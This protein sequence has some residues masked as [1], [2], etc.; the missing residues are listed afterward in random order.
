[1]NS[2]ARAHEPTMEEILASIRR[3][4]ADD[5]ESPVTGEQ[6][7]V[8]LRTVAPES[9]PV[10]E[11]GEAVPA[12][13]VPPIPP[14]SAL[15]AGPPPAPVPPSPVLPVS[16]SF[17][18]PPPPVSMPFA[19][20][21]V[22]PV[23]VPFAAPA[24]AETAQEADE[25]AEPAVEA[26][27]ADDVLELT[28]P[29]PAVPEIALAQ[30]LDDVEF[31]DPEPEAPAAPPPSPQVGPPPRQAGLQA[32]PQPV[33]AAAPARPFESSLESLLSPAAD[34]AVST[35]FGSLAHTILAQNARTLEDVVREML[36]PMLKTWLDDNLPALVERLV[37]VEIERVSR[38]GRR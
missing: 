25:P 36:R 12:L 8:P 27:A 21:P 33:S 26:P 23:S 2:P 3:I 10:P 17:A 22:P 32:D 15:A 11:A 31:R 4:I 38:G 20:P 37:R 1:M 18:A 5:D 35:A 19:V 14:A 6:H 30:Q 16:A 13:Q 29:L 34:N 9:A 7:G 28:D 24:R